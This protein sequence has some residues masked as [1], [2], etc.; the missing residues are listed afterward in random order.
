MFNFNLLLTVH[1]LNQSECTVALLDF[2]SYLTFYVHQDK[3]FLQS[4]NSVMT[5]IQNLILLWVVDVI[6]MFSN[7]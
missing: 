3:N 4:G 7:C 1:G 5:Y 2:L 6:K